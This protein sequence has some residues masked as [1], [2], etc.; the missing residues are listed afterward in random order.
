[1]STP[2]EELGPSLCDRVEDGYDAPEPRLGHAQRVRVRSLTAMQK[3]ALV[4]SSLSGQTWRLASDEGPY[5]DGADVAPP[6]LAHLATGMVSS[7]TA[8]LLAAADRQGVAVDDVELV[9]DNY[10]AINGSLLRGTMKGSAFA[11]DLEV[12]V[13][14]PADRATLEAVVEAAVAGAPVTGLLAGARDS[15]F[16]LAHNGNQVE[17]GGVGALDGDLRPDPAADFEAID[18]SGGERARERIR[19]TGRTTEPYEAA[20]DKYTG[21]DAAGYADEQDRKIHLRATCSLL[22]DGRKRIEQELYSPRGSIFEF[23]SDEPTGHGGQ[24]RAPDA[25]SYVAAGLGFCFMTQLGRYAH[26]VDEALTGYR[27]VQD[28]HVSSSRALSGTDE[29]AAAAP[30]ETDLF[31]DTPADAAFARSALDMSE[32]TCYLHALC[33]TPDLEPAVELAVA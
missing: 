4:T 17:P 5:L 19:H 32:Q 33:R 24:G 14:S 29:L 1:M 21:S 26:A 18:R 16:R 12:V 25:M 11:P 15:R 3:E 8:E 28:T 22:D 27:L 30:V 7:Y 10:Y 2:L 13:E 23:H 20:D 6:P 9:L 31:I